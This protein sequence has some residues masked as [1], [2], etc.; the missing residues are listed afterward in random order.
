M[1]AEDVRAHVVEPQGVD[2]RVSRQRVEAAGVHVEDLHP[3]P[4][5][6]RSHIAPRHAAV[7]RRLDHAVVGAD[8][9][10]I[11]VDVRRR[12]GVDDAALGDERRVGVLA[13]DG[14]ELVRLAGRVVTDALPVDPPVD[15]F[16]EVVV[17]E[18]QRLPVNGG[19]RHGQRADRT[20]CR[21]VGSGRGAAASAC[22]R[23]DVLVLRRP[24]IVPRDLPSVDDVGVERIRH[25][26]AV[27][28]DTHRVP[29]AER[30][31][32]V[33]AAAGHARRAALLLPAADAIGEVVVGI[34]VIELRRR[35][36]V[37]R[38][39][40]LAVVQRNDGP[41][42]ARH[43]DDVR[44]V[45]IDPH[46]LVVIAA[47]GA[48][49]GN[50]R[51]A[52]VE[53]FVRDGARH[54]HVVGVLR[55]DRG[56]REIAAADA[57]GRTPVRSCLR[58][59]FP[60]VI[61]APER[62]ARV[63][64]DGRVQ[65]LRIAGG[66]REVGLRDVAVLGEAAFQLLPR[67]AAIGGLVDAAPQA[68]PLRVLP[69]S[70]ALLPQRGIDDARVRW[71]DVHVVA[72]RVLVLVENLLERFA[73]IGRTEDA[74][75][76]VR[77]IRMAGHGDKEPVGVPGVDREV[78]DLLAVAQAKV[79]PGLPRVGGLVDAVSNREVG[80]AESLTAADVDHVRIRGRDGDRS[81][82]AGRLI[83]EDRL[84]G[85]AGIRRLPHPAVAD[86]DVERVRLRRHADRGLGAP[87]AERADAPP[88]H[89][90]EQLRIHRSGERGR[91]SL[92]HRR[93][94]HR[95]RRR[96]LRLREWL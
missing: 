29:L 82:R 33:V 64:R 95:R 52:A 14:R 63:D 35:L 72:A 69:R 75:L 49:E 55:I 8:P 20:I 65:P 25:H 66:D 50:P 59:G 10:A 11:D 22:H 43:D 96:L 47:G 26:V 74:A 37:P 5:R 39:P 28:L 54:D 93:P 79:R 15:R 85:A 77:A 30:D 68:A 27:F 21:R 87:A 76:F 42:I 41:L 86:A 78:G 32:A 45:R 2:R 40:G 4:E 56:N 24:S 91:R 17:R 67:R 90:T 36:V 57:A 60:R 18:E 48:L 19:E 81:D 44:I 61:R 80:T 94:R 46:V 6:R 3:R 51:L 31:L 23:R 92:A 7:R 71:I 73:T 88:S 12:D 89:V 83:V 84:P 58:P 34:D 70:L 62:D 1:R 38:A 13:D 9:D 53:G 16:P